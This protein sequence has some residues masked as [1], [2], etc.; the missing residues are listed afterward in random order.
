ML[1]S[2][3]RFKKIVEQVTKP[4]SQVNCNVNI[5]N[6]YSKQITYICQYKSGFHFLNR[7][8]GEFSEF[9]YYDGKDLNF[10]KPPSSKTV[11]ITY[12]EDISSMQ[13]TLQALPMNFSNYAYISKEDKVE[14]Y[15][16]PGNVNGMGQYASYVLKESDN[17]F[18]SLLIC[19]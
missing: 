1:H 9:F 18:R 19:L 14:K 11:E 10:G 13:M 5:K 7:L 17:L 16:A 8:S 3:K 4:L 2:I 6:Q 15:D 12:G